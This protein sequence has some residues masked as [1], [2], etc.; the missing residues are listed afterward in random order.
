MR[1]PDVV[2]PGVPS[3]AKAHRSPGLVKAR[4]RFFEITPG[5]VR[6]GDGGI[7]KR[8]QSALTPTGE[9]DP[10]F[11]A[12]VAKEVNVSQG[13]RRPNTPSDVERQLRKEAGFGCAR[14]GHPYIEYHHIIPVA[15]EQHFRPE[16]MV[17]LCGN[18]H[19]AVGKLGQDRQ[20]D[21]KNSP[22]N[23]KKGALNGALEFDKRDLIFKVGGN[24]F[25]NTPTIL[26]F[27]NVPIISCSLK[28]GQARV[29]LNLLD[30]AGQSLLRVDENDVSFR[31]NDLWDFE[32]AHNYAVARCGPRDIAL[33]LD[34]RGPEAVIEGKIWLGPNQVRL[35]PT[36][37]TLPGSNI[38]RG[39]R[40]R[41]GRVG[42]Q[43][44]N[45]SPASCG[46]A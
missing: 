23:V 26:Q 10:A 42:I 35:G 24:W 16:D 37:T 8:P 3:P 27:F 9:S 18:C 33:R 17:A 11:C 36:E 40:M 34:F 4:L 43:I 2:E 32:Y 46:T 25:E 28:D 7:G 29:S 19:P 38:F 5:D 6:C 31:V 30:P 45:P 22:Y 20:Y 15:E 41:G 21:I 44:G 14:C 12:F 39:N 13:Y 1:N